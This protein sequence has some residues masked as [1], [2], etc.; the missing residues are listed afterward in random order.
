VTRA[1][2]H[3][4]LRAYMAGIT[5]PCLLSL[6]LLAGFVVARHAYDVSA[7]LERVIAFPMAV[8]PNAWGLWNMLHLARHG[9]QRLS[10]GAHGALLPFLL[11]PA[12]YA[13]TRLVGFEPPEPLARAFPFVFP[14]VVAAFYLA[15]KH[16][17]GFLNELLGI[18]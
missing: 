9:R 5:L 4:Y 12:A 11:A 10:V 17:V 2:A 16:V 14:F 15:W 6:L 1:R 3:P 8:A 7:P 18:A 13:V